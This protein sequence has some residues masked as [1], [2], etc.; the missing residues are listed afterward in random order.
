MAVLPT[1]VDEA[2]ARRSSDLAASDTSK[3]I[4]EKSGSVDSPDGS[5]RGSNDEEL[6]KGAQAGVRAVEAA[7][8]V[9]S[10]THLWTAYGMWVLLPPSSSFA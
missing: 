4:N 6:E 7:T 9:W 2:P 5:D 1:I 8:S 3:A 10:K